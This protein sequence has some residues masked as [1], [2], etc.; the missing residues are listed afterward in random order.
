MTTQE[1]VT[2]PIVY[3]NIHSIFDIESLLRKY[4]EDQELPDDIPEAID[5]G[6]EYAAKKRGKEKSQVLMAVQEWVNFI[7]AQAG[8][9]MYNIIYEK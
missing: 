4:K 7:E 2:P 3:E 8:R 6:I 9:K 5:A 1:Q